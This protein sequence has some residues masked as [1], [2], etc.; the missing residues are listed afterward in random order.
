MILYP[1]YQRI[2]TNHYIM[3][4]KE[5][6]KSLNIDELINKEIKLVVNGKSAET[7]IKYL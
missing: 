7:L 4:S 3:T 2:I 6:Q 5:D 1:C